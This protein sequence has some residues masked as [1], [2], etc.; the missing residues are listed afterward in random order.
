[1]GVLN[2]TPDSFSDG[3]RWTEPERAVARGLEML[4]E[5]ADLLDLGAES[6]RPAGATYGEGAPTVGVE[7]EIERLLP[8]LEAL[9]KE[10]DAPLSVDTRKG[11]VAAAALEAGADLVND[12]TGLADPE[13]GRAVAASE[14]PVVLMHLRGTLPDVQ[15]HA[16]Y[17]DVLAEVTAELK[18]ALSRAE[19]AGIPSD[20]TILDPGL[21]FAKLG[22]HNRILLRDLGAL[23]ALD[24]PLLV[25]A[26][27]KS[28]LGEVTGQP[29]AER[30]E[31]SL[32]AAA[33]ALAGGAAI[34][35]VH[36]V[37]ATRRFV[38]VWRSIAAAG[39]SQG[40]VA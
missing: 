4:A 13:L 29:P 3:G 38:D 27:R 31:A 1:M 10:T 19:A 5:G 26:S 25:G 12:V 22:P 15:R 20:R 7:R 39:E 21:G 17:E 32:A 35:R 30:I 34:L 6:T 14:C 40:G 28:F 2:L 9:R 33:F 24:R 16:Q 36:D 23:R 11:R 37:A 8:V 18:D